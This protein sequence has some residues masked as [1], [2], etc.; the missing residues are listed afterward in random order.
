MQSFVGKTLEA[1]TL[2]V[3]QNSP[4]RRIHRSPHR[5]LSEALPSQHGPTPIRFRRPTGPGLPPRNVRAARLLARFNAPG[6][7][8]PSLHFRNKYHA[9]RYRSYLLR[10]AQGESVIDPFRFAT[11]PAGVTYQRSSGITYA[12][13]KSISFKICVSL[14]P[15]GILQEYACA[16]T[17]LVVD[18]TCT[19]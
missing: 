14:F 15:D 6:D 9:S 16:L 5:Q 8:S 12:A 11:T 18:F 3:V 17:R 4:K 19:R 10:R 2:N 7:F 1:I 13:T